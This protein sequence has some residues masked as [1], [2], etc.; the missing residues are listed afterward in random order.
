[1]VGRSTTITLSPAFSRPAI[2]SIESETLKFVYQSMNASSG[3]D[4]TCLEHYGT[5]EGW[6]CMFP[7]YSARFVDTP[8]FVLQAK[9]DTSHT[10]Q[11]LGSTNTV[12]VNSYGNMLENLL[13]ETVF[14]SPQHGGFVDACYHHSG[15]FA[16]LE[17]DGLT[18]AAAFE[19]WYTGTSQEGQK[20]WRQTDAFPAPQ[21]CPCP[22]SCRECCNCGIQNNLVLYDCNQD[23]LLQ[24]FVVS[25]KENGE[26]AVTTTILWI[27]SQQGEMCVEAT[28]SNAEIGHCNGS[29]SQSWDFRD[30]QIVSSG[31]TCFDVCGG[32]D[33]DGTNLLLFTCNSGN[34]NQ[35]FNVEGSMIRWLGSQGNKCVSV[36]D[37]NAV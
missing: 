21:S 27:G 32:S 23:S 17:A 31:G 2:L 22:C 12:A 24:H 20:V 28:S 13:D 26:G 3:V 6:M 5:A 35:M 9:F 30:S 16:F 33:A 10:A 14:A 29:D 4:Q 15:Q 25:R 7:Q 18:A 11:I 1:L 37:L 36:V 8:S 19:A 34:T